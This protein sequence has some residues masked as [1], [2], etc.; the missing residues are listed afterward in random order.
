MHTNPGIWRWMICGWLTGVCTAVGQGV[1][2]TSV[3]QRGVS[4]APGYEACRDSTLR[5]LT[6]YSFGMQSLGAD[7]AWDPR[8]SD[9][10]G[11][12]LIWFD[13]SAIPSYAAVTAAT[14]R[15]RF[16]PDE[17]EETP[18]HFAVRRLGDPDGTGMWQANA[19]ATED[20]YGE[21]DPATA[22]GCAGYKRPNTAGRR[23]AAR[24]W[25]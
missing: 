23:P 1:L 3:F 4:P 20:D 14:L 11:T 12:G 24:C 18:G 22:M 6:G 9:V 10:E 17:F 15:I 2:A 16:E 25:T 13:V 8:W 21:A 7:E 19:N 5:S